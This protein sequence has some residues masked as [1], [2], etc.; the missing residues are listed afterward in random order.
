MFLFKDEEE[1]NKTSDENGDVDE[2]SFY[3]TTFLKFIN[4]FLF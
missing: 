1:Q 2:E 3:S 4:F